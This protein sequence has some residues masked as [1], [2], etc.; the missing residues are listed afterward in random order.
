MHD[1]MLE[2]RYLLK[3]NNMI[4]M[5]SVS[6]HTD[7]NIWGPSVDE[8]DHR[9]FLK[10]A[11]SMING[12]AFGT[13]KGGQQQHKSPPA[14]AFRAF[15]GGTTL[16]PGRHFATT[17]TMAVTTMF[18]MRY[19]L[20]PIGNR[21]VWPRMTAHKTHAVA[22]VEQMDQMLEVEVREREGSEGKWA[23]AMEG[24]EAMFKTVA[25]DL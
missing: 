5:P 9:R 16:C 14:S 25:E 24:S 3:K 20:Q 7:P 17:V 15:G 23:F 19:D 10:P 22:A 11:K 21:G 12:N 1:T 18:I 6:V 13:E 2:N 4:L 8:F